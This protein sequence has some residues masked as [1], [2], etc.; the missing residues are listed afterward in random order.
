MIDME[1]QILLGYLIAHAYRVKSLLFIVH[2]DGA[3]WLKPFW[4]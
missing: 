1:P 4:P 2:T 3:Q